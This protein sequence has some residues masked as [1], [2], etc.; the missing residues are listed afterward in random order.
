MV[1]KHEIFCEFS[2]S[3]TVDIEEIQRKVIDE[4]VSGVSKKVSKNLRE[5]QQEL[6]APLETQMTGLIIEVKNNHTVTNEK[7][8]AMR[9]S[10]ESKISLLTD[11]LTRQM[12]QITD[13]YRSLQDESIVTKSMTTQLEDLENKL[14]E[15]SE[16]NQLTSV[17]VQKH[18]FDL[19][20][21]LVAI[22]QMVKSRG[23]STVACNADQTPG[24]Y[25]FNSI[26][27]ELKFK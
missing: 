3:Q 7:L 26:S 27:C 9:S 20:N 22:Q 24:L 2:A 10:H 15:M 4:V 21:R 23:A 16:Q 13:L 1:M 25:S 19:N 12:G 14:K 17:T 11:T 18:I 6:T 5:V 8:D